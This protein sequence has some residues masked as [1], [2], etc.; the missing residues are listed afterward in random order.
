MQTCTP[1]R[2][3]RS[4]L[5]H[6]LTTPPRTM[7]PRPQQKPEPPTDAEK[8]LQKVLQ[9][10]GNPCIT[11]P[12]SKAWQSLQMRR[13]VFL[14]GISLISIARAGIVAR[15]TVHYFF[16]APNMV[17]YRSSRKIVKGTQLQ[18]ARAILAYKEPLNVFE[19]QW[20]ATDPRQIDKGFLYTLKPKPCNTLGK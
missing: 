1:N 18:L 15:R 17:G 14:Y 12:K 20:R 4:Q 16:H 6:L 5:G 7:A 2:Q 8:A 13:A 11:D 3:Q 10:W 19:E 9:V